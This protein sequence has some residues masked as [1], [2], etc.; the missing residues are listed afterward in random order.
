MDLSRS[1]P[2]PE[3]WY[4]ET[5]ALLVAA[6]WNFVLKYEVPPRGCGMGEALKTCTRQGEMPGLWVWEF[7]PMRRGHPC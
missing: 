2:F 4:F 7:S 3:V 1:G 5:V 6:A